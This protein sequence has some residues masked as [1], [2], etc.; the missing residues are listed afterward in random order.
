M[1]TTLTFSESFEFQKLVANLD[2]HFSKRHNS[3]LGLFAY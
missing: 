3:V 2:N 1:F